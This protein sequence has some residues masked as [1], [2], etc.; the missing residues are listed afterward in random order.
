[1][2]RTIY[3]LISVAISSWVIGNVENT[4]NSNVEDLQERQGTN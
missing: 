3:Q 4:S 1:M 2:E